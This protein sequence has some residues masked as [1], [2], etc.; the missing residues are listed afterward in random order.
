MT[1]TASRA[2]KPWGP[3][4]RRRAVRPPRALF[5]IR[6]PLPGRTRLVLVTLSVLLPVAAWLVLGVTEAVPARYLPSLGAVWRA[7]SDMP[8]RTADA[9]PATTRATP[10]TPAST[11]TWNWQPSSQLTSLDSRKEVE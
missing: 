10:S 7:G 9:S 8:A 3:L 6:S 5:A 11:P 1:V 2:V 4:P